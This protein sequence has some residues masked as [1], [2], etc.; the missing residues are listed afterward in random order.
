MCTPWKLADCSFA[1]YASCAVVMCLLKQR[2]KELTEN[3][4]MTSAELQNQA[5]ALLCV[6]VLLYHCADCTT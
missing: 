1:M 2:H 5:E 4:L 3:H 6:P